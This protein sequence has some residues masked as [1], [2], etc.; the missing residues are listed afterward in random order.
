MCLG[1]LDITAGAFNV[2]AVSVWIRAEL[3][4]LEKQ[5]KVLDQRQSLKH[6]H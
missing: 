1:V 5:M 6:T 3:D 4:L 2:D